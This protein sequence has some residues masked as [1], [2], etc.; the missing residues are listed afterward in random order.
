VFICDECVQICQ[1]ILEQEEVT[2]RPRKPDG[3]RVPT[4]MEIY[5]RLNEHVVG[6]DRAKKVLAVAVYNHYKR[7]LSR[8]EVTA[9]AASRVLGE[10][11]TASRVLGEAA[12]S[13]PQSRTPEAGHLPAEVAT[14]PRLESRRSG[15]GHLPGEDEI[16]LQKS[17]ILLIGPT[18]CGKTL[19][20]QTLAKILDVP[21]AMADATTLTEAG[22]VG[23]DVENILL[24]LV[25]TADNDLERASRGIVYLDE[26]DK[27]ARKSG[28]NPSI[29]RDVSG[30]GVQQGL[31][32]ILEGTLANVPQ[33]GGRKHPQQHFLQLN[34]TDIL[35]ICGGAFEG[36]DKIT[37]ARLAEGHRGLGFKRQASGQKES[38][39]ARTELL[40]HVNADDLLQFGLIPE[41]V[42][43][44]PV[45]VS[46]DPLDEDMLMCILTQP[47]NSIIK[48]FQKLFALDGVKLAF[49]EDALRETAREAF[50]YRM[51]ARGLRSI[52]EETLLE[53]MYEIPSRQDVQRVV[54]DAEAIR[55]RKRP[56]PPVLT[57]TRD[58]PP[59][60]AGTE[61]EPPPRP[62]DGETFRANSTGSESLD[63]V[64][65]AN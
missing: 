2:I 15:A 10:A 34:T 21:F 14:A 50:R 3:K 6:Q 28:D 39:P 51:G 54:I 46:V 35:F 8:Q 63:G 61:G 12:S 59:R 5:Q 44:L 37:E 53:V 38:L 33:Q 47:K 16:E 11:A 1:E 31:L 56:E 52:I 57:A 25:R 64:E 65:E 4:P 19:L 23:E 58:V 42:G 20:A 40:Q 13:H 24:R 60:G 62:K 36:L 17:N 30:E 18:G 49:T 41:F 7:T 43:R 29:T 22:Y 26:V 9:A 32:K 55:D 45:V 27:I 48:Q